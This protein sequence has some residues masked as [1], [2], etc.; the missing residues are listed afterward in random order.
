MFVIGKTGYSGFGY[1]LKEK[2]KSSKAKM[3]HSV[4]ESPLIKEQG[5]AKSRDSKN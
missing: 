4:F 5:Y 2:P 1:R 3:L